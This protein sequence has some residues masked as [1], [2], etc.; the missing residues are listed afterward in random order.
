MGLEMGPL[1]VLLHRW[2]GVVRFLFFP[3]FFFFFSLVSLALG[4][5][6]RLLLL[7]D[8]TFVLT[9][10]LDYGT[11]I[12]MFCEYHRPSACVHGPSPRRAESTYL[13]TPHPRA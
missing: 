9:V 13:L 5:H 12:G 1:H 6:L 10:L 2:D 4:L 11:L 8:G 7:I 3:F